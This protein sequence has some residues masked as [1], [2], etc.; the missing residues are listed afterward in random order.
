M[1]TWR[2]MILAP[3]RDRTARR[4]PCPRLSSGEF[5]RGLPP[6]RVVSDTRAKARRLLRTASSRRPKRV[7]GSPGG[8]RPLR[9]GQ[10][11]A[12]NQASSAV[13]VSWEQV[14]SRD[15]LV[16]PIGAYF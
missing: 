6:L 16:S 11:S 12:Q 5:P 10:E 14:N 1:L 15:R 13:Q 3:A 4:Q 7:A 8:E 2:V 9:G